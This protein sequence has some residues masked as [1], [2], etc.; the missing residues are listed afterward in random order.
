M[1]KNPPTRVLHSVGGMDRGGIETSLIHLL[2]RIDRPRFRMDFRRGVGPVRCQLSELRR[3]CL[4]SS[5]H[6]EG[7]SWVVCTIR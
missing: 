3:P 4:H 2:R 7:K 5:L 6:K 1:C